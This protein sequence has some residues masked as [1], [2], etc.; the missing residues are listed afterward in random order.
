MKQAGRY[1]GCL[2]C[3]RIWYHMIILMGVRVVLFWEDIECENPLQS[4]CAKLNPHWISGLLLNRGPVVG[5]VLAFF[6]H[7]QW[8]YVLYINCA[9][10][11]PCHPHQSQKV[12]G[13]NI[14]SI[15]QQATGV[16]Q[17]PQQIHSLLWMHITVFPGR[18]KR[19]SVV[20]AWTLNLFEMNHISCQFSCRRLHK[21]STKLQQVTKKVSAMPHL[22]I[23]AHCVGSSDIVGSLSSLCLHPKNTP[24]LFLK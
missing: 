12:N 18:K 8:L 5:K 22:V 24:M 23:S 19:D 20:V 14:L 3:S 10:T 4:T 15:L 2:T 11:E 13:I 17:E 9:G 6:S 1:D 21:Y 7:N 16:T